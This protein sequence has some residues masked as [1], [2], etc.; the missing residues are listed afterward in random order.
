MSSGAKGFTM[1]PQ[2]G[3]SAI[4]FSGF[5]L[6]CLFAT[7]ANGSDS[8][9]GYLQGAPL[10]YAVPKPPDDPSVVQMELVQVRAAQE[11]P[12]SSQWLEANADDMA[13]KADEVIRRFDDASGEILDPS[14]RVVLVSMLSRVIQDTRFYAG[15]A[16]KASPRPRPYIE[17]KTINHCNIAFLNDQ[18]SYPSGHAMN[19]YVVASVLSQVIPSRRQPI[20]ARGIRYGDNRIV[21]GVHHP[22]D[23]VEGRMLGIAYLKALEA[24]SDFQADLKCAVE[25]EA[26]L[27][28]SK[29]ALSKT[30]AARTRAIVK[31]NASNRR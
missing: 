12:T 31:S 8:P 4:R 7:Q 19:G 2:K 27:S 13:Y 18:E 1:R 26:H 3:W 22:S 14:M 25:E 28:A 6:A 11:L 9:P 15:E 5:L 16:K 24:N 29:A 17:D 10:D 21:C 23:V 30:C 20:L